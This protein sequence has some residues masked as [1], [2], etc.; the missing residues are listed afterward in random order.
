MM[1][2]VDRADGEVV[3]LRGDDRAAVRGVEGVI[4]HLERLARSQVSRPREAPDDAAVR[5]DLQQ[6]VVRLVRD[7]HVA[8]QHAGVRPRAGLR[9]RGRLNRGL[10]RRLGR[11][12]GGGGRVSRGW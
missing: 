10:R 4:G 1:G 12:V 6:T 5:I 8:R 2:D 11:S 9:V 7:Q 3:L